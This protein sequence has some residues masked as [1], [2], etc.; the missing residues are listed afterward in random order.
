M[1]SPHDGRVEHL[2]AQPHLTGPWKTWRKLSTVASGRD[3]MVAALEPQGRIIKGIAGRNA[4][5]GRQIEKGQKISDSGCACRAKGCSISGVNVVSGRGSLASTSVDDGDNTW[6]VRSRSPL[7]MTCSVVLRRVAGLC[8]GLWLW[9]VG[10][11]GRGV[12]GCAGVSVW[13]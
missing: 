3:S 5:I 2:K 8:S 10:V 12:V 13:S 11:V 9:G 7:L 6:F 1:A 4:G